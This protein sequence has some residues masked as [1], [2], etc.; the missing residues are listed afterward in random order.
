MSRQDILSNIR[1]S[2]GAKE[3][4]AARRDTAFA[5][6]ASPPRA[7]A[8]QR[9]AAPGTDLTASFI[10]ELERQLAT[11]KI[12]SAPEE[13][14]QEIATYLR[15]QNQPLR[16][17]SGTDPLL[18]ELDFS[19]AGIEPMSG[20]AEPHDSTGLSVAFGGI[21]ETGTLAFLS[22]AANPVTLAFL[23][24]THIA[25]IEQSRIKATYEDVF[26]MLRNE[27]GAGTMPR[28]L[29]MISGP[30]RTADIG[31]RIVIG[32]HGPRRLLA[33]ILGNH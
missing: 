28:T 30:S 27:K 10:N 2:L 29:N 1:R 8:P 21:A 24:D 20:P 9:V 25:I 31:G 12:V 14:P 6:I 23:P 5:R 13:I 16:L 32:A 4:D 26:V 33:I 17:R 11:V 15:A 3:N 19:A 18:A 7:P 22:G